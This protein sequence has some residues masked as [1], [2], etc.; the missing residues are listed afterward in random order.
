MS[1][2]EKEMYKTETAGSRKLESRLKN[3]HRAQCLIK[4]QH[5]SL[6]LHFSAAER[7]SLSQESAKEM[8]GDV[9]VAHRRPLG[10]EN[11][12]LLLS[13]LQ[14]LCDL[15]DRGQLSALTCRAFLFF[16]INSMLIHHCQHPL[17]SSLSLALSWR[18]PCSRSAA[19][20]R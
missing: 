1:C 14:A 10:G 5:S 19:L 18:S 11:V 6:V 20:C 15:E 16:K 4:P 8:R 13:N 17:T 9:S 7:L 2:E 3:V 12:T